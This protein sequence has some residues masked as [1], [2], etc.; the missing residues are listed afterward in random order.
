MKSAEYQSTASLRALKTTELE[1]ILQRLKGPLNAEDKQ[2][3]K[4]KA[5]ELNKQLLL[6]QAE[7]ERFQ[8]DRR[9]NLFLALK[10]YRW[11]TEGCLYRL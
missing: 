7:E 10:S 4:V 2:A 8:G 3:Y 6:D 5:A 9:D 11:A 1:S